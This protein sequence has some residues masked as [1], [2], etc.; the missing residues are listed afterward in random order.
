MLVCVAVHYV[1]RLAGTEQVFVDTRDEGGS[2]PVPLV[3]GRGVQ[4]GPL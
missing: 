1:S 2:D 3:A 4:P